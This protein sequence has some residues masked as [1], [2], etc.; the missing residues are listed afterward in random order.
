MD[1]L[2]RIRKRIRTRRGYEQ[3]EIK[4]KHILFTLFYRIMMVL[5]AVSIVALSY[6]INTKVNLVALPNSIADVDL[7]AIRNLIPFEKWFIPKQ[8][9]EAVAAIPP[10]TLLQND[11]YSNGTNQVTSLMEGMVL[12]LQKNEDETS[13]ITI[14]HDNGVIATYDGVKNSDI[15]EEERVEKG[16]VLGTYDT[17]IQMMFMRENKKL[18][19]EEAS[20]PLV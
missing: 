14:Q 12:H 5:M 6:F 2:Q 10:Y 4:E 8:E 18:S 1:D 15:Q 17:S 16:S 11:T 3:E 13:T 7:S 20:T 19:Y 9:A